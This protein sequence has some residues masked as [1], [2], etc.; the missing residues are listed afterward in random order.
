MQDE[1]SV[2]LS[3][4][5][6]IAITLIG[7]IVLILIPW[8]GAWRIVGAG[9]VGVVTR[10]GAVQRVANPGLAFKL[11]IV[12]GITIMETRIQKEQVEASAASKDLQEVKSI[13]ASS[14]ISSGITTGNFIFR[15]N[16]SCRFKSFC[17]K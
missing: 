12:E 13:I 3:G 2:K 15:S 6:I 4:S 7:L 14:L 17:E 1:K 11:P 8:I 16:C 10:F 5:E 9:K